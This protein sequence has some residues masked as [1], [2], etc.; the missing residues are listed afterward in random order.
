MWLQ[1]CQ[2]FLLAKGIVMHVKKGYD[3]NFKHCCPG[4][5]K[6][7]YS[8]T[9]SIVSWLICAGCMRLQEC[10]NRHKQN[11]G[12]AKSIC[13]SLIKC[14]HCGFVVRRGRLENYHCGKMHCLT[15]WLYMTPDKHQCYMQPVVKKSSEKNS[16]GN[17]NLLDAEGAKDNNLPLT[18]YDQLF[19]FWVRQENETHKLNLCVV[20]KK[21][22]DSC[23]FQGDNTRNKFCKWLFTKGH[24]ACI[25]IAHNFQG[26][27]EYF[28]QKYLHENGVVPKVIMIMMCKD[29]HIK[30]LSLRHQIHRFV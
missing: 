27:D 26:Y 7:C 12:D 19:Q 30:H 2:P 28:I 11:L 22:G 16:A 29:S 9:C 3:R 14:L 21:S 1:V 20:H 24:P 18:A 23:V 5:G 4:A 13:E 15:C 8:Q 10:F 6:L 17:A 25:V